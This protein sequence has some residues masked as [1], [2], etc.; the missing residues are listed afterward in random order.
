[1]IANLNSKKSGK[2]IK[3][4]N[5]KFQIDVAAFVNRA[6][7]LNFKNTLRHCLFFSTNL[8]AANMLCLS[9]KSNS[10]KQA[11]NV[12][13]YLEW[14]GLYFLPN[15]ISEAQEE[16]I[17]KV[18]SLQE[19]EQLSMR[20]V[21][22]FGYRFIYGENSVNKD[23]QIIP[24]PKLFHEILVQ[25]NNYSQPSTN[26]IE[27]NMTKLENNH[28]QT[29]LNL[30]YSHKILPLISTNSKVETSVS[31]F[32]QVT[33]NKYEPGQGIPPHVDSHSP[34]LEPIISLSLSGD[35]VMVFKNLRTKEEVIFFFPR[36]CLLIMTGEARYL[37]THCIPARKMDRV[38]D[39]GIKFRT[40][41]VSLTYRAIKNAFRCD[42][43]Y[44]EG[45]D[46]PTNKEK[47]EL[48]SD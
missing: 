38:I 43:P 20:K 48:K 16:E 28:S 46:D 23:Y 17:L 45:C 11:I 44:W 10:I 7:L 12:E 36:K 2:S 40:K 30:L 47:L 33:V 19:F 1:M 6:I 26:P 29:K 31:I 39:H 4:E 41:R 34:F 25:K 35:T 18:C 32:D 27:D 14:K 15:F 37:W 13:S 9:S 3:S 24:I 42:C 21:C 8:E 22:H 5:P